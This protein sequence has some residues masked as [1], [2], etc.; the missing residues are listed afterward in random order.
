LIGLQHGVA[1]PVAAAPAVGADAE[2]RHLQSRC[3]E[4]PRWTD[5]RH[6][7]IVPNRPGCPGNRVSAWPAYARPWMAGASGRMFTGSGADPAWPVGGANMSEPQDA[8]SESMCQR[9][10]VGVADPGFVHL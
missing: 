1:G 8:A 2:R 3:A 7:R 6:A 5:G 4:R 9:L 10:G